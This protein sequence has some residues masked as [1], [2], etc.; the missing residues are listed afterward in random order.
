MDGKVY[1][2]YNRCN[3]QAYWQWLEDPASVYQALFFAPPELKK[4][5][6]GDEARAVPG[7]VR[8]YF[9]VIMITIYL[10][11]VSLSLVTSTAVRSLGS[12][13][14][15]YHQSREAQIQIQLA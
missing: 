13:L 6:P 11:L 1:K 7:R 14:Y 8:M 15:L 4:T 5:G 12:I 9:V 2:D 3:Y 10:H